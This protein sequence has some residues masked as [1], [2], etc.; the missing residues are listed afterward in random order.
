MRVGAAYTQTG[1]LA[2]GRAKGY[3]S[4]ELRAARSL[5]GSRAH[6]RLDL[7]SRQTTTGTLNEGGAGV[8]VLQYL[9]VGWEKEEKRLPLRLRPGRVFCSQDS[10][11]P[12]FVFCCGSSR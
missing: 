8:D 9:H 12:D 3:W 1:V 11:S 4:S 6:R 2:K 7:H 5:L 10:M